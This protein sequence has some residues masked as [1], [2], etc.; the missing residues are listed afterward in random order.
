MTDP[1]ELLPDQRIAHIVAADTADLILVAPATA[2]WM[3]AMAA[4]L[5]DDVITA[6]C[7][8]T[9]APVVVAPAMDGEMYA[10]PATRANVEKLRS[11]G[12]TIVEPEFG[13]LASGQV[14][15]GRLAEPAEILA[16]VHRA[17]EGRPIR[18]PDP[19][20][21]P[22]AVSAEPTADL[23]G[24]HVVVTA[25]GTAEPIDPVRYIG[26]R[27]TGKMGV[28]IAEAALA[29]G[30][31]VTLIHGMTSVALPDEAELVHAPSAA[32]MREAVLGSAAGCRRA[33][34]GRGRRRLPPE[35]R[36]RVED[37]ANGRRAD[38]RVG[39]DVGHPRRGRL[40]RP[41]VR[42]RPASR[43]RRFRGRDRFTGSRAREGRTQG[44]G[45][46]RGQRRRRGGLGLRHG[47]EPGHD[48]RPRSGATA[49][50][51]WPLMSKRQVAD[52]LARSRR[53]CARGP[54][55]RAGC[56]IGSHMSATNQPQ[57]AGTA[58]PE[59]RITVADI[60]KMR[61]EG[62]RIAM[63]T[64]YDY[65]TARIVDEAGIPLIL[66]GD[67]LGMVM[68][69]YEE[70]VR[71]TMDEMLHHT[72]AVVRGTRRSLVVGDMPFMS[73]GVTEQATLEHAA[74]FI[75]E[76]GAQA[77]KIEGGVRSA[78]TIET[79]ARSRHP[80]HGP[81]RADAAVRLRPRRPP[82][83]G[84]DHRIGAQAAG[85]RVCRPGVGRVCGRP[86]TGSGGACRG[87]DGAAEDPDDR[88]RR[89]RGCSGQV[90]VITDILGLTYGFIP[91]HAKK[92][93]DLGVRISDA[94]KAYASDV[95]RWQ[96]PGPGELFSRWT[97]KSSPRSWAPAH[98]TGHR[99][100]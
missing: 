92:Y 36:R 57:P 95:A 91:K 4:G 93:E 28:A 76:G 58:K 27:S 72:K 43:H 23:A 16:A 79:I 85:R 35:A 18:Q 60:A 32:Q 14:G 44:R 73:Y 67:S 19:P 62:S 40:R 48:R 38:D 25:G 97:R 87:G 34:H 7:L 22:P 75:S 1:L 59:R 39:A 70:T 9:T 5:A 71:V 94:V 26:N 55:R 50:D 77:V 64:A 96:L 83:A 11:F 47:H 88:H 89:R 45:P 30:A 31:R 33:G 3:A 37:R 51:E 68:L 15:R 29:R 69:G 21:R 42:R 90:Q 56:I 49:E 99:S 81:H 53:R 86:R 17:L 24:W 6:T 78:R 61:A 63:L 74:R 13:P 82:R 20:L 98:W 46:A 84:Q 65:P 41:G 66:V 80:G 12:Y 100:S 8:A 52:R 10:H 54:L 2:R